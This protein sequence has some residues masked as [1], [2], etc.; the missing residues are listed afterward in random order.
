MLNTD[1]AAVNAGMDKQRYSSTF[2]KQRAGPNIMQY[3]NM[4]QQRDRLGMETLD[5]SS[6]R[7]QYN[8]MDTDLTLGRTTVVSS[9]RSDVDRLKST[10]SRLT[11]GSAALGRFTGQSQGPASQNPSNHRAEILRGSARDPGTAISGTDRRYQTARGYGNTSLIR[12]GDSSYTNRQTPSAG[13]SS[14][15]ENY[16]PSA[17]SQYSYGD[18][19][20]PMTTREVG[21]AQNRVGA[22]TKKFSSPAEHDIRRSLYDEKYQ[23]EVESATQKRQVQ[24]LA[25]YQSHLSRGESGYLERS[26]DR[27]L[28][29]ARAR[30]DVG[31]MN[32]LNL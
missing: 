14:P 22:V 21:T 7:A 23:M 6:T 26:P 13:Y 29:S 17:G 20:P 9:N 31:N 11:D 1:V 8:K 3:S 30:Y 4:S 24:V 27:G 18:R 32:V 15:R 5:P 12:D 10:H 2:E 28:D 16:P 19:N 25:D